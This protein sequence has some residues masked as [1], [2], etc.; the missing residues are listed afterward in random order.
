LIKPEETANLFKFADI[1]VCQGKRISISLLIGFILS[2]EEKNVIALDHKR[3]GEEPDLA[4]S[5][6]QRCNFCTEL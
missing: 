3:E 1:V 5:I 4:T 2:D 6:A